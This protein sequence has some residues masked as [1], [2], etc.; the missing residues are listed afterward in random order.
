MTKYAKFGLPYRM[1]DTVPP[2]S[3]RMNDLKEFFE[4]TGVKVKLEVN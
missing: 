4:V 2:S 1:N 3:Q